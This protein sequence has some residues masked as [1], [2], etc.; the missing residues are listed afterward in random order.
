[1]KKTL[2]IFNPLF[3]ILTFALVDG[4]SIIANQSPNELPNNSGQ[5]AQSIMNPNKFNMNQGFTMMTSM[6][7]GKRQTMGV[8]SN[9][10]SFKLSERLQFKTGLHLIQ[11]QNNLA[12]SNGPQTGIGYELGV[13]YKLS[14]NSILSFQLVNYSNSPIRNRNLSPLNVP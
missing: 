13:E 11:N 10:S 4:Q 8:Y 6:S 12:Y 7:G 5:F 9:Y 14:P 2:S 3:L 1:M